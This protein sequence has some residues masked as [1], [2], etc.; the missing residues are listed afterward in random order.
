[1]GNQ[2]HL[3]VE[4][5][6]KYLYFFD[7]GC[8]SITVKYLKGLIRLINEH[9]PNLDSSDTSRVA[10]MHYHNTLAHVKEKQDVMLRLMKKMIL[11]PHQRERPPRLTKVAVAVVKEQRRAKVER[12]VTSKKRKRGAGKIV[13]GPRSET[14]KKV[15]P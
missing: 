11:L 9:I 8:P 15:I 1:M 14:P 10:R 6:N 7:R 5:L 12:L 2:V 4:I 3:F 13:R